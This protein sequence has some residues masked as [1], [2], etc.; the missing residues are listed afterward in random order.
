M[1][2]PCRFM[3]WS[4]KTLPGAIRDLPCHRD[5]VGVGLRDHPSARTD[6]RSYLPV[7]VRASLHRHVDLQTGGARRLRIRGQAQLV[8]EDLDVASDREDVLVRVGLEGIEVEEQVVGVLDVLAAGMQRVHLDAAQVDDVQQRGRVVDHQV[9]DLAALRVV[10]VAPCSD[11]PSPAYA[12]GRSSRRSGDPP[13]R[14]ASASSSAVVPAR[15][16]PIRS[17][18]FQ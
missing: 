4:M 5:A 14:P 2:A 13:R 18:T 15:W 8:E 3:L 10:R 12:R 17:A 11:G 9:V 6:E 16:G 7:G 1:L